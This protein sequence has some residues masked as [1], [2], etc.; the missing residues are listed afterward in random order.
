MDNADQVVTALLEDDGDIKRELME[1]PSIEDK[2]S[3]AYI[4]AALWSTNDEEGE[5]LDAKYGISDLA[6]A[7]LVGM[8]GDCADF[9]AKHHELLDQAGDEEQNGH[10]YW[11]SRN[12]HGAGFFDRGYPDE[13]G[14]VLQDLARKEGE[15][16]LYVGDDGKIYS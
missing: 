4:T 15:V 12:G 10:D 11:L 14:E 3:R 2:F 7:T 6:P 16:N 9:Q 1:K 13:V 5:P 8:L